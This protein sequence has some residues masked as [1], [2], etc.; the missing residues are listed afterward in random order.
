MSAMGVRRDKAALS[1]GYKS[2]A[3]AP[4]GSSRTKAVMLEGA[5][6]FG[7]AGTAADSARGLQVFCGSVPD[8]LPP[9]DR[10]R[11]RSPRARQ[12]RPRR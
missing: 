4:A 3:N 5:A 7:E 8:E 9:R 10:N 11:R 2:P 1:G 6:I 12:S